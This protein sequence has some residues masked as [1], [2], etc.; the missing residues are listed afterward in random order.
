M[1]TYFIIQKF[2][3]FKRF[4][5][6]QPKNCFVKPSKIPCGIK[7]FAVLLWKGFFSYKF[8]AH[9]SATIEYKSTSGNML[10][11]LALKSQM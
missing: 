10:D 3:Q 5:E 2:K 1:W 6:S 7:I 8:N 9:F 11:K 4:W